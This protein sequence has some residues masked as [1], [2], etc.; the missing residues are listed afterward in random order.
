PVLGDAAVRSL[1]P[2]SVGTTAALSLP[3]GFYSTFLVTDVVGKQ[4]G[5]YLLPD[6]RAPDRLE[7]LTGTPSRFYRDPATHRWLDRGRSLAGSAEP[8]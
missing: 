7:W 8:L 1:D 6:G 3:P 5:V 2:R 4:R